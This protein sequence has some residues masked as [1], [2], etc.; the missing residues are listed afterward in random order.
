M[1]DIV[2]PQ[3]MDSNN[4][5]GS[6]KCLWKF[7]KCRSTDFNGV[8]SLKVDGKLIND[9]KLKAE[10]LHH[11]FQ[12]VFTHE[13]AFDVHLPNQIPSMPNILISTSGV[14][15]LLA[16]LQPSKVAGPD[17]VSPRVLKELSM[18]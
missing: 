17:N 2:A 14:Q 15:K 4:S 5:F 16:N 9:P 11:Q 3:E 8:A 18:S 13:Y 1:G 12:S 7:I 10:A 6:M